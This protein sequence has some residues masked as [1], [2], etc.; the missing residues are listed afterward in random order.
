MPCGFPSDDAIPVAEYGSSNVGRMKHIYRRGLGYRYGRTMQTIA[1]CHFNY[2][3][4]TDLW[5][6]L[7]ELEQAPQTDEQFIS[8]RYFDLIRNLQ[9]CGWLIL[10]LFGASPA[11]CKA[12]LKRTPEQIQR[13]DE[14]DQATLYT[15]HATSLRMSD[16]GYRSNTQSILH[17]CYNSLNDYVAS[18]D[19]K[20]V[21]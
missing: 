18:L 2:S 21:V 11:I 17:I 7:R 8:A 14:F 3:V 10:Y 19:R 5:S 15:P 1:G 20:S 9:R 12:F 6:V 16:I 13:F 4:A